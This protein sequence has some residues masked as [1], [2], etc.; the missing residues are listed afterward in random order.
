MKTAKFLI[1]ALL[2]LDL[3]GPALAG[4]KSH[5]AMRYT[6]LG[7]RQEKQE[8]GAVRSIQFDNSAVLS[9]ESAEEQGGAAQSTWE[10]YRALASGKTEDEADEI[11]KSDERP[12]KLRQAEAVEPA[13]PRPAAASAAAAT[14]TTGLVGLIKQYQENKQKQGGMR[15]MTISSPSAVHRRQIAEKA[16]QTSSEQGHPEE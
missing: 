7:E 6:T 14:E 8:G 16:D 15:S 11:A 1:A 10:R 4:E 3:S 12:K 13:P 2:L 9:Q 5:A